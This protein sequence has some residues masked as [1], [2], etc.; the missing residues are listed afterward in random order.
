MIK[1]KQLK[2]NVYEMN[3][4]AQMREGGKSNVKPS[5][6]REFIV[7]LLKFRFQRNKIH[8]DMQASSD[9]KETILSRGA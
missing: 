5:T 9:E 6:I 1:A 8:S 7:N 2:L 3:V 4:F